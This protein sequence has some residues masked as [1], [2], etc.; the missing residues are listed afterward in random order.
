MIPGRLWGG[1]TCWHLLKYALKEK[2]AKNRKIAEST[3]RV[4]ITKGINH[5]DL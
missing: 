2:T 1:G 4:M 3:L 5:L